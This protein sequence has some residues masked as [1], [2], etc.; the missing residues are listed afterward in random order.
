MCL[1]LIRSIKYLG[2]E[3]NLD[4]DLRLRCVADRQVSVTGDT[5]QQVP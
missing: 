5:K 4:L 3:S 1:A 2:R